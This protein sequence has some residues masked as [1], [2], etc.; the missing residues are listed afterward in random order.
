MFVDA[1]APKIEPRS[2]HVLMVRTNHEKRIA[3][4]LDSRGIE[5]FLPCYRSAR[6]WKDRRVTLELPLFPGYVFVRMAP[7]EHLR[8]LMIPQ[9]FS[10]VG[11]ANAAATVDEAEIDSIRRGIAQG[12][13]EPHPY[14]KAGEQVVITEGPMSGITGIL[15]RRQNQARVVV[16]IQSIA[17]S[18][19]VD[20]DAALVAP[21]Q[22]TGMRCADRRAMEC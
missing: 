22:P 6:Q 16:S 13:A 2:W 19:V 7:D 8:A 9:V 3:Q 11:N 12:R 15:L 14:L 1:D 5:H 21:A 18:F 20:I 17:R 4:G 10:L